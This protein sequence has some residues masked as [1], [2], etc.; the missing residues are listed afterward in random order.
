MT[1]VTTK[2]QMG[3]EKKTPTTTTTYREAK[4]GRKDLSSDNI[5]KCKKH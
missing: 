2:W 3:G 4:W 5:S 1:K